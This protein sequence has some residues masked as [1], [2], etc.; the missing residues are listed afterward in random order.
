M[1]LA[2]RLRALAKNVPWRAV[3][4]SIAQGR[5][6]CKCPL[7]RMVKDQS[8]NS[9]AGGTE[10]RQRYLVV[11]LFERDLDRHPAPDL[12]RVDA[13]HVGEHFGPLLKLNRGNRVRDLAGE[14]RMIDAM[15]NNEAVNFAL[16]A[17]RG[18]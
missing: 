2:T 17:D 3:T 12:M 5:A 4:S 16:A 10:H 7:N 1:H 9:P 8:V 15:H 18:P 14:G 6:Q 11:E 13:D